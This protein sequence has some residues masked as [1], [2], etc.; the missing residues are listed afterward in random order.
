MCNTKKV[1]IYQRMLPRRSL[2]SKTY[3]EG[4][5]SRDRHKGSSL[6]V[7]T[8]DSKYIEQGV[9]DMLQRKS[10]C[11][12]DG[13]ANRDFELQENSHQL[14]KGNDVVAI[15]EESTEVE[16]PT[17]STYR[18]DSGELYTEDVDQHI[19]ILPEVVTHAAEIF[20]IEIQVGD[21]GDPLRVIKRSCGS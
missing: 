15:G 12:K 6:E 4:D 7:K 14:V 13:S 5:H 2:R 19:T 3:M 11:Q 17:V 16:P 18:N 9:S 20:R 1:Y 8:V 21:P 10:S